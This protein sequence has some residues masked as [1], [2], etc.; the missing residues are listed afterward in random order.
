MAII[1]GL[2]PEIELAFNNCTAW[3]HATD[4]DINLTEVQF[5]SNRD[6]QPVAAGAAVDAHREHRRDGCRLRI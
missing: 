2:E 5:L 6:Q 3:W 4:L 1:Q